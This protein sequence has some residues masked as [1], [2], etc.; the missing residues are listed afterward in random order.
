MK[1]NVLKWHRIEWLTLRDLYPDVINRFRID[2]QR[3]LV[4]RDSFWT[5]AELLDRHRQNWLEYFASGNHTLISN[6]ESVQRDLE[7]RLRSDMIYCGGEM[8]KKYVDA[9]REYMLSIRAMESLAPDPKTGKVDSRV[10]NQF[11]KVLRKRNATADH[12]LWLATVC[13]EWVERESERLS[14]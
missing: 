2:K 12:K 8:C 1:N 9:E 13:A 10:Y 14:T 7:S 5:F 6:S 4:L 3:K 11:R